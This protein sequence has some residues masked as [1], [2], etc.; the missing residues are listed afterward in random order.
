MGA[1]AAVER[2]RRPDRQELS[3]PSPDIRSTTIK[4]NTNHL[5]WPGLNSCAYKQLQIRPGRLGAQPA[6]GPA[7]PAAAGPWFPAS[8]CTGTFV[9]R[10]LH[11]RRSPRRPHD[12][13]T[14]VASGGGGVGGSG[15]ALQKPRPDSGAESVACVSLSWGPGSGVCEPGVPCW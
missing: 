14:R 10:E 13:P 5:P 2:A 3:S 7:P 4:H 1:G 6:D 15:P 8:R 12:I 11:T 9:P